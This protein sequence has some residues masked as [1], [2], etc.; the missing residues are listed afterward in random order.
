MVLVNFF[1]S[2]I[3]ILCNFSNNMTIYEVDGAL[4]YVGNDSW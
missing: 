1:W 2:L 4:H 3:G